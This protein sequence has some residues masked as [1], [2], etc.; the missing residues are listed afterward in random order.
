MRYMG[1]MSAE[2]QGKQHLVVVDYFSC[3]IFERKL[4]NLTSLCIIDAIKDIFCDLGSP[5]KIITDN[6]CYFVSEEFTKFVMDWSIHHIT[7]SVRYPQG[8]GM[9]EKAVGIVKE[10]YAKCDDVKLGLLLMKTTPVSNQCHNFQAPANV[11]FGHQLKANLPI[12]RQF[13][14]CTLDAKSEGAESANDVLSKYKV[15]QDVW[16]KVDPHTKWMAGKISQILPNQ[17]YVVELT[18]GHVFRRNEH[19]ITKRQG[20]LKPSTDFQADPDSHSYNLR[21]RKNSKHVKWPDLPVEGS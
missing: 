2:I 6:A 9:A 12:Y 20:C 3:C 14:T 21:S 7:S 17:S 11:F 13:D 10:L 1:W 18:D 5:D 8:N 4:V 19:H 16:V 15:N